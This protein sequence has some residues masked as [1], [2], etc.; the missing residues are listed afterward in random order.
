MLEAILERRGNT[1]FPD[2]LRA[3]LLGG[4]PASEGL[5]LRAQELKLPL[6]TTW[7]MT[8][9]ASQVATAFPGK[10][11]EDGAVGPP[12]PFA[13]VEEE[14]GTLHI[15]GPIVDG[16]LSTADRGSINERGEIL[17]KGRKDDLIISGGENID[18]REVEEALLSHPS[19][20]EAGVIGIPDEKWGERMMAVLVAPPTQNRPPAKEILSW[21]KERLGAHRT[22]REIRWQTALPRNAMGKLSR[23]RLR[24]DMC[25]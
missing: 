24:K 23:G 13:R 22:P 4:A 1:P 15:R 18:P 9:A 7:G 5:L 11:P 12:L 10:L 6:A 3:I 21:C 2:A 17:V 8:E 16:T 19:I 25:P 14:S 20:A